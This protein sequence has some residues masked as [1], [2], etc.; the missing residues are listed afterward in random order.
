MPSL[1]ETLKDSTKFAA[2]KA[3]TVALIEQEVAGKGGISGMAI[4]AGFKTVRGVK[5]GFLDKVVGELLPEFAEVLDPLH[6]E[7]L[8]GSGDVVGHFKQNADR[9]A[10]ALLAI[11]DR[12][13]QNSDNKVIKSAYSKLRG[14]AKNNVASAMPGLAGVI[15]KHAA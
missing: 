6:Q 13:A 9:A 15:A 7:A 2:V 12:K 10:D 5:P 8:G 14:T 3:D 4:K 1:I 11:T